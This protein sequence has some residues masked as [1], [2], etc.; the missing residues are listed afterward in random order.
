M[1]LVHEKL[2]QSKDC[3]KIN[4]VD[5]VET[6]TS[7]LFQVYGVNADN[8]TLN[9]NI[10]DISLNIDTAIPCGLIINELTSNSLKYAFPNRKE[11]AIAITFQS[12]RNGQLELMIKDNGIGLLAD[13]NLDHA[14]SLGLKLVNVLTKQ[15]EGTIAVNRSDGTEFKISFLEINH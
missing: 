7:Y 10:E 14:K 8:I 13:F 2:Y 12:R 9:L 3:A 5:Y 15:L 4:F 6:L 11:G 1:A